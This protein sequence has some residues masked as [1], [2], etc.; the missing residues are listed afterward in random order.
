MLSRWWAA[1][2]RVER[3]GARPNSAVVLK[4]ALTCDSYSHSSTVLEPRR[5]DEEFFGNHVWALL[6]AWPLPLEPGADG[7]QIN[8]GW[9]GRYLC[10]STRD[11]Q[12]NAPPVPPLFRVFHALVSDE[13]AAG[14]L[15]SSAL[16]HESSRTWPDGRIRELLRIRLPIIQAGSND[17]PLYTILYEFAHFRHCF[18]HT[19]TARTNR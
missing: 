9:A 11:K 1:D 10:N 16:F 7:G 8:H 13:R 4:T 19:P 5:A 2:A 15:T 17:R 18:V 3:M 6:G 14:S 12:V